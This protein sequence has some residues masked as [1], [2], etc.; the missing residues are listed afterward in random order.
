MPAR[1]LLLLL[2][3]SVPVP[4]DAGAKLR[5]LGLL[6]ALRASGEWQVD[7]I[8]FG[9]ADEQA[10]LRALTDGVGC[11][12]DP[13]RRPAHKR[14]RDLLAGRPDMAVRGW[15]AAF[16]TAVA[17]AL[18]RQS[19]DLVQAEGIEMAPYLAGVPAARR[20][21]DAHNAEFLLQRRASV[22]GGSLAGRLYSRVQWRRLERFER[23]LVRHS[24]LVLAVSEHDAN[25]L[26]ALA[27]GRGRVQVVPNGIDVADYPFRR[28]GAEAAP[29]LLLLGKLDFRPNAEAARWL[30]EAVLP[31]LFA[32]VP[33]ARLFCVGAAPPGW[34]VRAGQHDP[35]LAVTGYV[36]DERPYLG[37]AMAMLLP[38]RLGGGTRLKALVAMASGL[39]IVSTRLGMEGLE[40]VAD[41]HYLAAETPAE[42]VRALRCLADDAGLRQR[43]A[44]AARS[45][46]EQRYDWRAIGPRLLAAY[47][48]V[49]G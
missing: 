29:N 16:A 9:A 13:P 39:P 26:L 41:E 23:A 43:L 7:T 48:G 19:Y 18:D 10:A 15:S 21:Y 6:R 28:P 44:L 34:L 11:V 14:L 38:L 2:L 31:D 8:A 3:P 20:V 32:E 25:Q 24:R 36:A 12:I 45:L 5:N 33:A 30:V 4:A 42:W 37:R 1:R 46:V 35:R 22:L 27:G 47:A 40:A 49:V 17:G